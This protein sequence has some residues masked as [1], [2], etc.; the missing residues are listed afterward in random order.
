MLDNDFQYCFITKGRTED[1]VQ[2]KRIVKKNRNFKNQCQNQNILCSSS[3]L[4]MKVT[5]L[6]NLCLNAKHYQ[7]IIREVTC[8]WEHKLLIALKKKRRKTFNV[9]LRIINNKLNLSNRNANR[10]NF[11]SSTIK[12]SSLVSF[13]KSLLFDLCRAGTLIAILQESLSKTTNT[14]AIKPHQNNKQVCQYYLRNRMNI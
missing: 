4:Q 3:N 1:I 9:A 12:I 7:N 2:K 13:L 8:C 10:N 6:P 14:H 11:R 5:T